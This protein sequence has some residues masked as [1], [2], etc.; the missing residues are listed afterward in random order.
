MAMPSAIEP[1]KWLCS[2]NG[3]CLG[4]VQHTLAQ[5]AMCIQWKWLPLR[6][7]TQTVSLVKYNFSSLLLFVAEYWNSCAKHM[8]WRVRC[9][10][11]CERI[12][13][14]LKRQTNILF[15]HLLFVCGRKIQQSNVIFRQIQ[16]QRQL[17][18]RSQSKMEKL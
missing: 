14:V 11:E 5:F 8:S 9:E 1:T 10:R 12:R 18:K 7:N 16:R 15:D 13:N 17:Q 2:T 6:K 4:A 3:K